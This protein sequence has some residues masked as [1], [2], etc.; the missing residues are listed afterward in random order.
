MRT[1]AVSNE[2]WDEFVGSQPDGDVVQTSGW[3]QVKSSAMASEV[4]TLRRGGK[5]VAGGQ[6]AARKFG[7]LAGF[8]YVPYGPLGSV[9]ADRI[10]LIGDL[11]K[12]ARR[13]GAHALLVQP[14]RQDNE[15]PAALAARGY[16]VSRMDVATPASVVIDLTLS[17][18][19]LRGN[20]NRSRKKNL[21][22]AT[23]AGVKVRRGDRDDLTV[24]AELHEQS[25]KRNGFVPMSLDYLHRQWDALE[26]SGNLFVLFAEFEGVPEAAG[27]FIGLG[28]R[29]EFKLTGWRAN[30]ASSRRCPNDALQWDA[31]LRAKEDGYLEF[32]MGGMPR[33]HAEAV[34]A[35]GGQVPTELAETG[36]TFKLGYGGEVRVF[37]HC[38]ERILT[39]LGQLTYRLPSRLLSDDGI[40]GKVINL[41]RRS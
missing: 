25:A 40:G 11:E 16:R 8:A 19:V 34:L 37:P 31:L 39:P 23:K 12:A 32:D 41:L 35:A 20:L 15:L 1:D 30:Q 21:K 9:P 14:G 18:D 13:M 38:Y 26:P 27:L 7:P 36:T 4:V 29:V 24:F 10:N 28:P 33:N 3:A 5:I 22:K 6:V 17:S 2:E